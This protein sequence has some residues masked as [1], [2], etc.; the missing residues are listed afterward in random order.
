MS[1]TIDDSETEFEFIRNIIKMVGPRI[2]GSLEERA[3]AEMIK[4]DFGKIC[5][6]A[7]L[8]EFT[9]ATMASVGLI[10]ALGF[11]LLFGAIPLFFFA[12]LVNAIIVGFFLFF[13]LVQIFK[14][15]AWFDVFFPKQKSQNVHAVI[16]PEPAKTT[17]TIL[18]AGHI[19]SAW[20]WPVLAENPPKVTLKLVYGIACVVVLFFASCLKV[21]MRPEAA[22]TISWDW[23]NLVVIPMVPGFTYIARFLK[24][25]KAGAS[26]GA[27]DD[28]AGLSLIRWAA[29]YYHDN[30]GKIPAGCRLVIAAFGSEEAGLKGSHAF[31]DKHGTDFLKNSWS[32]IVDG[33]SDY[34]YFHVVCGDAWLGTKYDP[35]LVRLADDAM[36]RA[37][38]KH[39]TIK[40]PVGSTDGASFVRKGF[41]VVTLAAQ[42]PGPGKNYHTRFDVVENI[43]K[44]TFPVMKRV[45]LNLIENIGKTISEQS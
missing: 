11:L 28:L 22:F 27:M 5:G 45:L 32:I 20:H 30:P 8:E 3:A 13:A 38:I 23:F 1:N 12:P 37:P 44:R 24:W 4:E 31:V 7:V 21:L 26:P 2:A 40:N 14:Y 39:D 19:D 25:D 33:V 18:L 17:N 16:D 42:D 34:E 29:R 43:D 15:L 41:K 9:C 36:T 35:D 10:P 6:N